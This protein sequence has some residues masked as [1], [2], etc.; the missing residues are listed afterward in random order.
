MSETE[1]SSKDVIIGISIGLVILAGLYV[2]LSP[3]STTPE[4]S[5]RPAVAKDNPKR[6]TPKTKNQAG[7]A[8]EEPSI[9]VRKTKTG[10][11]VE[12]TEPLKSDPAF[13]R[14]QS[15]FERSPVDTLQ[16]RPSPA[17]TAQR[18]TQGAGTGSGSS[19]DPSNATSNGDA[20]QAVPNG[21]GPGDKVRRTGGNQAGG[22]Y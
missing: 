15:I 2:Y 22:W 3:G 9:R 14:E 16:G 8:S 17:G 10:V 6:A 19:A 4:L 5:Q 12:R 11:Y 21:E 1:S 20:A 7:E 13:Y 18:N